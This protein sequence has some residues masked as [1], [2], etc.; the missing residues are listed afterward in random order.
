MSL[1]DIH[2]LASEGCSILAHSMKHFVAVNF[3]ALSK[4]YLCVKSICVEKITNTEKQPNT[5][6]LSN[7]WSEQEARLAVGLFEPQEAKWDF[8]LNSFLSV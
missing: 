6:L 3:S 1:L 7:S 4:V 8:V 5:R 2:R